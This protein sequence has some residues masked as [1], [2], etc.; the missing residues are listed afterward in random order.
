MWFN[1][2]LGKHKSTEQ[3]MCGQPLDGWA[4]CNSHLRWLDLIRLFVSDL[5]TAQAV[6]VLLAQNLLFWTHQLESNE[7][8]QQKKWIEK[9]TTSTEKWA[10]KG[11]KQKEFYSR[12]GMN[13]NFDVNPDI[14][15]QLSRPFIYLFSLV[16]RCHRS[17]SSTTKPRKRERASGRNNMKNHELLRVW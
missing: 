1:G 2:K 16:S 4:H 5:I 7:T 10:R 6:Q 17:S 13:C 15:N 14:I 11:P 9:K 3:S 8:K 12:H